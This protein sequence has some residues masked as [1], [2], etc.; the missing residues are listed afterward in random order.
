MNVA[1]IY[2]PLDNVENAHIDALLLR[3]GADHDVLALQESPHDIQHT[4][5]LNG[6][7]SVV[8]GERGVA[9]H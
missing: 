4:G 9:S 3:I 2:F 6:L 1:R 5:L 8:E 7:L